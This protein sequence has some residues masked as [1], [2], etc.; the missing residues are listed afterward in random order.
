MIHNESSD[1]VEGE[2]LND[3]ASFSLDVPATP[4][5]RLLSDFMPIATTGW[6]RPRAALMRPLP[7]VP[8]DWP[9]LESNVEGWP[10]LA[11]SGETPNP[12]TTPRLV[13]AWLGS[14]ATLNAV[15]HDSMTP[16]PIGGWSKP[17]PCVKAARRARLQ[18]RS[19]PPDDSFPRA[20][21]RAQPRGLKSALD[22]QERA[23]C[24]SKLRG[25]TRRLIGKHSRNDAFERARRAAPLAV[26]GEAE[27][28]ARCGRQAMQDATLADMLQGGLSLRSPSARQHCA[29]RPNPGCISTVR[30]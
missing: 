4:S 12:R 24:A 29:E 8:E 21:R 14:V 7:S 3:I 16:Q 17:A 19:K 5:I 22:M 6:E 2:L 18:R 28:A 13:S 10:Q 30:L 1:D 20:L 9:Q 11:S 15:F 26:C 25:T 23:V 27:A